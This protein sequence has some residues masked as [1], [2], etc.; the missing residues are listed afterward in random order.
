ML[1][2]T[3]RPNESVVITWPDRPELGQVSVMVTDCN[4]SRAKLGFDG[5]PEAIFLR[6]EIARPLEPPSADVS[7]LLRRTARL[8]RAQL[9]GRGDRDRTVLEDAAYR[10]T[11]L[12]I[13]EES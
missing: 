2:L 12:A 3:R 4:T 8:L 13:Q 11:A 5:P 1:V 6:S 7:E 10:L 9:A